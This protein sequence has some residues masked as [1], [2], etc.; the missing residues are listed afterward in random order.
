MKNE[1]RE[2]TFF[3]FHS[4]PSGEVKAGEEGRVCPALPPVAQSMRCAM[5]DDA[6]CFP[7]CFLLPDSIPKCCTVSPRNLHINTLNQR[8]SQ[9]FNI[10]S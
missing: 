2:T 6:S 7:V 3:L 10:Y 9:S 5:R 1:K 4:F 8:H